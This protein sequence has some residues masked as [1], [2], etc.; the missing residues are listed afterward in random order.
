MI[1]LYKNRNVDESRIVITFYLYEY[2]KKYQI[3]IGTMSNCHLVF[4]ATLFFYSVS[5]K[6]FTS[7][8]KSYM[9]YFYHIT[10]IQYIFCYTKTHIKS[11]IW[12]TIYPFRIFVIRRTG[13]LRENFQQ[14]RSF[15]F[16]QQLLKFFR[17]FH[18]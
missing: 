12:K 4:F 15:F 1:Y 18:A 7:K 11:S 6:M 5:Y 3:S 9:F 14:C 8:A 17:H 16:R 13:I 10:Y 2:L